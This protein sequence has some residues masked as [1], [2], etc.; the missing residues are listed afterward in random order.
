M[1]KLLPVLFFTLLGLGVFFTGEATPSDSMRTLTL[2]D[3]NTV[4]LN[5]PI[6]GEMTRDVQLAL[7]KKGNGLLQ[8]PVYLF[9]NSPG[10]SIDDGLQIVNTAAG[11]KSKV[12]TISLFSASMSFVLSQKLG[13]RYIL[14]NATIMS[15]R[16]RIEG[17][18]SG[19]IPGNLLSRL[20]HFTALLHKQDE[21]VAKRAGIPL[22]EYTEMV[23]DELWLGAEES[24]QH[25]FMDEIVAVRCDSSLEGST[26]QE[27][28]L[29]FFTAELEF[30]KCPLITYPLSIKVKRKGVDPVKAK[31]E[32]AEKVDKDLIVVEKVLEDYF[33][34]RAVFV[35]RH[36][37]F[38]NAF[39]G[40]DATR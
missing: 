18:L 27:L 16:A 8:Q 19:E 2:S 28:N 17:G 37:S 32:S 21:A 5:L 31:A 34:D 14:P 35:K 25:N 30:S 22:P 11:L 38:G 6:D 20:F 39:R 7:L 29:L 3:S 4:Q 13:R 33:R 10:G 23:R 12:H 9:L 15:H 1:N 40:L 36:G 24:V 26:K